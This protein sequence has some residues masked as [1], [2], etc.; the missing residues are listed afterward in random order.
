M[1]NSV[2]IV[3][4]IAIHPLV[5]WINWIT[6][7]VLMVLNDRRTT[8]AADYIERQIEQGAWKPGDKLPTERALVEQF[9]IARN[10][11][12]KSLD[13][14]EASGKITRHVGRGTFVAQ[15]K[16]MQVRQLT[17]VP[18]VHPRRHPPT[19]AAARPARTWMRG[20]MR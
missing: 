20:D 10:T 5:N 14:L 4:V 13:R 11:L 16:L 12:R 9:G 15:P 17:S 18:A 7:A 19:P 1:S 8:P 3:L 2:N 6:Q